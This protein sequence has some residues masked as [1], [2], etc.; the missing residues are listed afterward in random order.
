MEETY[1]NEEWVIDNGPYTFVVPEGSYLMLG[2]NRNNSKDSRYWEN[3]YVEKEDILGEAVFR[4][5]PL[6]SIGILE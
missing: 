4:Y 3:T 1:V 2:D 6:N 5:W